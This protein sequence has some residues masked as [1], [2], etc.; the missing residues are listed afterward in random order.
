M[1]DLHGYKLVWWDSLS[2]LMP[3]QILDLSVWEIEGCI[4]L[5]IWLMIPTDIDLVF[6][7]ISETAG[8]GDSNHHSCACIRCAVIGFR[9]GKA[10][11]AWHLIIYQI[12][13]YTAVSFM[14]FLFL[15]GLYNKILQPRQARAKKKGCNV[16]SGCGG[17]RVRFPH[18]LL[19]ISANIPATCLRKPF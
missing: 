3:F 7:M 5:C 17:G 10:A 2:V 1:G 4:V 9:R 13:L 16:R 15:D 12:V 19:Q 11:E 14:K 8:R 6:D 18:L